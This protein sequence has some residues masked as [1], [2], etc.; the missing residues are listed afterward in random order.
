MIVAFLITSSNSLWRLF[1]LEYSFSFNIIT[2]HRNV[3]SRRIM[4]S[5]DSL[6][7]PGKGCTAL[8]TVM[9][10]YNFKAHFYVYQKVK[11]FNSSKQLY[12]SKHS[13]GSLNYFIQNLNIV[14]WQKVLN[15]DS[16]TEYWQQDTNTGFKAKT[17]VNTI[18]LQIY[19]WLMV[20]F[21]LCVVC[22]ITTNSFI[23]FYRSE[24]SVP[25]ISVW[26]ACALQF[27]SWN[28]WLDISNRLS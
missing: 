6:A 13:W 18:E 2:F 11:I 3:V 16:R 7:N 23:K 8:V 4:S 28:V 22:H 1:S 5:S 24:L 9:R 20:I 27:I 14:L 12:S 10:S 17:T 21:V 19:K 15:T 26:D 25:Y